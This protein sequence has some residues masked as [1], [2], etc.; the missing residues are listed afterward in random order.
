MF[1]CGNSRYVH[2]L[3]DRVSAEGY[4]AGQNAALFIKMQNLIEFQDPVTMNA[5]KGIPQKTDIFCVLCPNGCRIKV[6]VN[7]K[8]ERNISG[9]GCPKGVNF[10]EQESKT[11]SRIVTTTVKGESGRLIP[12]KSSL[13]IS[14]D[15]AASYVKE[16]QNMILSKND[17]KEDH[18][19]RVAGFPDAIGC[20]D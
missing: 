8:G 15:K 10:V 2:D 5:I 17:L 1:L 6:D 12:V 13:P 16:C 9:N 20:Y 19:I 3:V 14:L 18:R 4:A 7:E 11:P